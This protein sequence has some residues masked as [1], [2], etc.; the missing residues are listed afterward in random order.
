MYSIYNARKTFNCIDTGHDKNVIIPDKIYLK[1]KER[2]SGQLQEKKT[3][4]Y[5]VTFPDDG[6]WS[7]KIERMPMLSKAEMKIHVCKTGKKVDPKKNRHSVPTSLQKAKSF[8]NDE[9]LLDIKTASGS[10]FFVL[11][12]YA[13]TVLER[14]IHHI[15]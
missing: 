13:I 1:R 12:P 11:N 3:T 7:T 2:Q 8:L 15:F 10:N 14:T 6:Q 4:D 9:Y 5:T